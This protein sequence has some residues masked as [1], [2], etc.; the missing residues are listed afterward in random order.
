MKCWL[1]PGRRERP[2]LG[3]FSQAII[4]QSHLQSPSGLSLLHLS[5]NKHA[6]PSSL[7]SSRAP[8]KPDRGPIGPQLDPL[9]GRAAQSCLEKVLPGEFLAHLQ[10]QL[11]GFYKA[12]PK[13]LIL[14]VF[15]FTCAPMVPLKPGSAASF[16][17]NKTHVSCLCSWF[18]LSFLK[19]KNLQ[20]Q[21]C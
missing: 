12:S 16:R 15:Q 1:G 10:F 13:P 3:N 18:F 6:D 9:K 7:G 21:L 14:V 4:Q 2:E 17:G 11:R 5:W 19:K 20:I 8:A